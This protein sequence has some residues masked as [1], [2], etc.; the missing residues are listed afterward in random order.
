MIHK[1]LDPWV[2]SSQA[3]AGRI[4]VQSLLLYAGGLEREEK[5]QASSNRPG[6]VVTGGAPG[7]GAR[8]DSGTTHPLLNL[9]SIIRMPDSASNV[10]M[11]LARGGQP[12]ERAAG[13]KNPG[14]RQQR[15]MQL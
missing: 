2:W 8:S 9:T 14:A 13:A 1:G 3:C 5:D 12:A 11:V 10:K 7:A 6:L 15:D 4:D